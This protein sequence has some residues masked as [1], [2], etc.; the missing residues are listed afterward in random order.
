MR[1]AI[2]AMGGDN[3]PKPIVQGALEALAADPTLTVV[4]VGDQ[5]QLE[6]LLAG[7]EHLLPRMEFEHTTEIVEM[8]DSAAKALR[9]TDSSIGRCWTLL[10]EKRVDGIV[11]AGN[12]GAVV[13]LGFRTKRFLQCI[14]RPGIA[15]TVPHPT[16]HTVM[17]DCGANV[18]PK[19]EHLFQYA[20]MGSI[21]AKHLL[22][23]SDPKIGLLNVGSEDAKGNGL[24]KQAQ[25]LIQHSP[26]KDQFFGNVEGRDIC[27]GTVDVIVCDGFSGNIALKCCEGMVELFLKELSKQFKANLKVELDA[28]KQCLNNLSHRY[29][30]SEFG[31]APLLGIDGVCLICHGSSDNKA[32]RNAIGAAKRFLPVNQQI[33]AEME[34]VLA[35]S[36]VSAV[37]DA[38]V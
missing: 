28:A 8:H 26:I 10:A 11:S 4:L 13:A 2:D 16:G 3:A 6:P 12:T 14:E 30:Y 22:G 25:T 31:G 33:V 36:E 18:H 24:A 1:V 20:V 38:P 21:F 29:S 23:V 7:H 34:S 37:L 17:L 19:P 27:K 9:K 15:V 35:A 5:D 32:I